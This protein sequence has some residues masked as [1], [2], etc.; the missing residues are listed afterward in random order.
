MPLKI[1]KPVSFYLLDVSIP[2]FNYN[3][4]DKY[5]L[6]KHKSQSFYSQ[7]YMHSMKR[8]V[9]ATGSHLKIQ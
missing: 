1:S 3:Y 2:E 4:P 5:S 6:C 8:L 9:L 7:S